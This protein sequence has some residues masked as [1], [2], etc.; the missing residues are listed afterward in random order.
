MLGS[1]EQS[2][3]EL[4]FVVGGCWRF[5]RLTAQTL[6]DWLEM[7]VVPVNLNGRRLQQK[8]I[9]TEPALIFIHEETLAA[10]LADLGPESRQQG[11]PIFPDL[12]HMVRIPRSP[13]PLMAGHYLYYEVHWLL[14]AGHLHHN[15]LQL[16]Q[17][18]NLQLSRH[19]LSCAKPSL[20]GEGKQM[21]AVRERDKACRVSGIPA[22]DRNRGRNFTG[23]HVAHIIPLF[24]G[25]MI[26]DT[27]LGTQLSITST[28]DIDIPENAMLMRADIHALFN[29]YQFGPEKL[30]SRELSYPEELNE[31]TR[32]K[33]ADDT[34]GHPRARSNW[35]ART[36]SAQACTP[37]SA[38]EYTKSSQVNNIEL[39]RVDGE[40]IRQRRGERG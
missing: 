20:N 22:V 27:P 38:I 14:A 37:S 7:V 10:K 12:R 40:V 36:P 6:Y 16:V 29:V 19:Y 31:R 30:G 3:N 33:T 2:G 26:V 32:G 39:Q 34:N 1:D 4:C 15:K 5:G 18:D 24:A 35:W 17:T 25:E 8:L 21:N 13:G 28:A 9:I 11:L 23:L